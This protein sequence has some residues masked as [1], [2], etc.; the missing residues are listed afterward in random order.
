[1]KLSSPAR[2]G[3]A[4]RGI[5][6]EPVLFQILGRVTLV[7]L[8]P[9]GTLDVIAGPKITNHAPSRHLRAY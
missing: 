5:E 2:Q 7:F 6:S 9:T 4:L 8:A 1:M 3:V